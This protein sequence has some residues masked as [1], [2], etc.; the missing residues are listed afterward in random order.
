MVVGLLMFLSYSMIEAVPPAKPF[1]LESSIIKFWDT[2]REK[3]KKKNRNTSGL[4]A[5]DSKR[6]F[7][8]GKENRVFDSSTQQAYPGTIKKL[9]FFRQ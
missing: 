3:E 7:S 1:P 8:A 4:G 2:K 5:V 6:I 9:F